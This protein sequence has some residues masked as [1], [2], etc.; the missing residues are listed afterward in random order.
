[1]AKKDKAKSGQKKERRERRERRFL[2]QS[3]TRPLNIKLLGGL[4]GVLLGAGAWAQFGRAL[5]QAAP[6]PDAPAPYPWA[7]WVIV[8]GAVLFAI[9]VWMGTSGEPAMR[10]GSGGIATEKGDLRRMAWYDVESITWD[11]DRE[12][13]NV[14]GK[15]DSGKEM[16]LTLSALSHPQACAWIVKEARDRI[17]KVVEVPDEP[18]GVPKPSAN[19]GQ[20]I[21]LDPVQVVGRRCMASGESILY[22]PDSRI[23][24]KCERVY[25]KNHVPNECPCGA[26]LAGMRVEAAEPA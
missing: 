13:L 16:N 17:P 15:D 21:V 22:E 1:M 26:S 20:S 19:E 5:L 23:C 10:V 4:G 24:P 8:G 12:S 2:P 3:T 14:R 11:N 25:H 6:A 9:A 18:R 7:P